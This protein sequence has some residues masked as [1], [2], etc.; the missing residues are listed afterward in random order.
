MKKWLLISLMLLMIVVPHAYAADIP[1]QSGLVLDEA[2]MFTNEEQV[3]LSSLAD[4][5]NL[6]FHILTIPSL[7]GED[8]KTYASNVYQK[9]RLQA[10]DVL[11]LISSEDRRVELNFRNPTLQNQLN[12]WAERQ[13]GSSR[14]AI[15]QLLDDQFIPYAKAGDYAGGSTSIMQALYNISTTAGTSTVPG[16]DNST[17]TTGN[18]TSS[19]TPSHSTSEPS[20][21]SNITNNAMSLSVVLYILGGIVVIGIAVY[22]GI[23]MMKKRRLD[24]LSVSL[25]EQL[26]QANH[27]LESTDSFNGIVQGQ[28]G[29]ML[30]GIIS[31]LSSLLVRIAK[32]QEDLRTEDLSILRISVLNQA[33]RRYEQEHDD[34][35]QAIEAE[36]QQ[37]TNLQE[38]DRTAKQSIISL[39]E[40]QELIRESLTTAMKETN[41][42]LDQLTVD[43]GQLEA[44]IVKADGLE[45]FDPI[46]AQQE[47]KIAEDKRNQTRK[48]VQDVAVY[49]QHKNEYPEQLASSRSKVDQLIAEHML[50]RIKVTPYVTLDQSRE[51]MQKL[52][53]RLQHGDMDEVRTHW[54]RA[55]S[56]LADAVAMTERQALLRKTNPVDLDKISQRIN[57]FNNTRS[58]ANTKVIDIR[59]RYEHHHWG[60]VFDQLEHMA[61]KVQQSQQELPTIS[62]WNDD[63]HQEFDKAREAIDRLQQ[64][65]D[66]AETVLKQCLD[67]F[68]ELDRWL[69]RLQQHTEEL[70]R[71]YA[72]IQNLLERKGISLR[73]NTQL[74]NALNIIPAKIYGLKQALQVTP[75]D[76]DQLDTEYKA[77]EQ[78]VAA[79]EQSAE[80]IIRQKEEAEQMMLSLNQRVQSLH[81][82]Y[83]RRLNMQGGYSAQA[84]QIQNLLMAG[85]YLEAQ[86]RLSQANVEVERVER[87]MRE[88]QMLEEQQR[89]REEEARFQNSQMNSSGGSSW[90]SGSSNNN[91]NNNNNSSGGSNW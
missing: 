13:S 75:H 48:N 17:N 64:Q 57:V 58:E 50:E 2:G 4:K 63:E 23:G 74:Q 37:M 5:G 39:K 38:A 89:R 55:D 16:A 90:G 43:M 10:K 6:T 73:Q 68:E 19:D 61:A 65:M 33:V 47:I 26:V 52:S 72:N 54:E 45:L 60:D 40:D 85:M 25:S 87:E 24:K 11:L 7:N 71:Q 59:A 76:L 22:I 12:A 36:Q 51:E 78:N 3:E 28:T 15:K 79:F 30:K 44:H 18:D 77:V 46:A 80:T 69:Q 27:V 83:A 9:W 53:E 14:D 8:S 21:G 35:K 66:E 1:A 20:E 67:T 49:V 62:V 34:I 41:F 29:E 81:G 88:A 31:R 42:S 84:S 86:Q 56:M 32:A 91:S 70:Q 82:G